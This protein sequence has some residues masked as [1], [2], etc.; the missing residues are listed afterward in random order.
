M[1]L[2][3]DTHAFVFLA[4]DQGQIPSRARE[5][6]RV[7]PMFLSSI[8]ALEIALLAK[9]GRLRLPIAPGE[10]VDRALEQH[11]VSEIPVDRGLAVASA[12]LPDMH[13]DPFDRLIIATAH[14]HDLVIV[15]KDEVIPQYPGVRALW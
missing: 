9:H 13:N 5:A 8:S 14:E 2:L 6:M 11:G 1:R 10:F 12:E 3:L 15:T 4:S 7:S